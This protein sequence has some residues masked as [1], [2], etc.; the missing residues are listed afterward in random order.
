M[1]NSK[2]VVWT[3]RSRFSSATTSK[4]PKVIN[5]SIPFLGS[6]PEPVSNTHQ[7]NN[8]IPKKPIKTR[9]AWLTAENVM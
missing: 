7:L 5:A 6:D 2:A 9:E 4:R 3:D 1:F 8:K